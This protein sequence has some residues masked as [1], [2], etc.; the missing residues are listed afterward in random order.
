MNENNTSQNETTEMNNNQFSMYGYIKKNYKNILIFILLIIA[1]IILLWARVSMN[2]MRSDFNQRY[3]S[4]LT[5]AITF[6]KEKDNYYLKL[7][8]Y[9]YSLAILNEMA[10]NNFMTINQYS[11][12]IVTNYKKITGILLVD[13]TGVVRS[14]T[15]KSKENSSINDYPNYRFSPVGEITLFENESKNGVWVVAPITNHNNKIGY[16]II[17]SNP[18]VFSVEK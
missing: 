15:D 14:S 11:T 16:L 9:T 2:N 12:A 18:D 6:S 5:K 8:S 1:G 13:A 10:L 4:L 7:F 3:D 17:E